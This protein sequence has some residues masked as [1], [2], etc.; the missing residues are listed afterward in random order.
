M[1]V[2]MTRQFVFP[3]VPEVRPPWSPSP[4]APDKSQRHLVAAS[5]LLCPREN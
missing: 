3:V 4:A 5:L 1:E 2:T